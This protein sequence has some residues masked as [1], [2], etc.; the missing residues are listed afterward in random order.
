METLT[1]EKYY[2]WIK[3]DYTGEIETWTNDTV[4]DDGSGMVFF[5]FNSGRQINYNLLQE[6][7]VEIPHP[8]QPA[9]E[10][11]MMFTQVQKT[12]AQPKAIAK[13]A[14]KAIPVN[15]IFSILEKSKKTEIQQNLK[16]ELNLP[17]RDLIKVVASSFDDGQDSVIDYLV[18][19]IS[20][21]DLQKQIKDQLKIALFTEKSRKKNE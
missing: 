6:F 15:P 13:P 12:V 17:P 1:K 8:S 3:G 2:Q 9:I 4:D 21:E 10:T 11:D 14:I 19:Q 16:I 20:V 18:S 5:I 7:M